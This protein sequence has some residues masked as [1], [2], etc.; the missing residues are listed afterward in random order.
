MVAWIGKNLPDGKELC[1]AAA[2]SGINLIDV[3]F[4]SGSEKYPIWPFPG[5][6]SR[7]CFKGCQKYL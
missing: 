7:R 4:V 2:G 3:T 5:E 6:I 1:K